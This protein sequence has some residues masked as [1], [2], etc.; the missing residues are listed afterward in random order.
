MDRGFRFGFILADEGRGLVAESI[1]HWKS[2]AIGGLV[3]FSHHETNV[4]SFGGTGWQAVVLGDMYVAH[5]RRSVA[6]LIC[7]LAEMGD[8]S[9]LDDLG[10][11]FALV[12]CCGGT[13]R[14][15]HDAFGSRSVYY[16]SGPGVLVG[17][18][19][20]LL[21]EVCGEK[22]DPAAVV[23]RDSPEYKPRG[24][25]YL[26]GDRTMYSGIF[27]LTPNHYY[28]AQRSRPV[29]FWPRHEVEASDYDCFFDVAD[30]YFQT[31]SAF[32]RARGVGLFGLTGGVDSRA[33]LAGVRA[34]DVPLRLVTW[35]GGRLPPEELPVVKRM[36]RHLGSSHQF[37]DVGR[38]TKEAQNRSLM[39]ATEIATGFSRGK[40]ALTANMSRVVNEGDVFVRGYGGEILRGFY[41]RHN[42][43]LPDRSPEALTDIYLTKRVGKP[44]PE[45]RDFAVRAFAEFIERTEFQAEFFN[46]DPLDIFYWEQRM[47]TW[48]SMMLNEMDPVVYSMAGMNS[49]RL[50]EA[51][52]GLEREERLGMSLLLRLTQRY[53]AEFASMGAVS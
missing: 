41:N 19:S 34:Y 10:G 2:F 26:P 31:F 18:H 32:L 48:G 39:D 1:S 20:A 50:F 21:A 27:A 30:E 23:Y 17:S 28:S 3:G 4:R 49:R 52:F 5:G 42:R 29:R 40:A 38:K 25:S 44:A 35:G 9:A 7:M 45:F 51:A 22:L 47:G 24:T 15:Y 14:L 36:V 11:R 43:E 37:I 12:L 46:H 33:L 8:H 6:E 16:R 53:D 13:V